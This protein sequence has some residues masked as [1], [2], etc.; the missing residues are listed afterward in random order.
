MKKRK[1][2]DSVSISAPFSVE[3]RTH[4][5]LE[6][7][8]TNSSTTDGEHF[9]L[10]E[11]I[12]EGSFG[13]VYKASHKDTHYTVA[14]KVIPYF[15]AQQDDT[16]LQEIQ[17]L[18]KC[19][20]PNV[21][22]YF[23]SCFKDN[24]LWILMDYC[25]VGSLSD[26]IEESDEPFT[27]KQIGYICHSTLKGLQFLHDLSIV[28]SDIKAANILL[29]ERGDIKLADFGVS[30]QLCCSLIGRDDIV[31]TPLYIAP[32]G[33]KDKTYG[34]KTDVWALGI[35]VIELA[36]GFP[37]Y[38]DMNP[39]RAMFMIPHKPPP[40]FAEPSSWSSECNAFLALCLVKDPKERASANDL[41]AHPFVSKA[42]G[43]EV[44]KA[45]IDKVTKLRQKKQK[46]GKTEKISIAT[47]LK[48]PTRHIYNG[49]GA[50]S[51]TVFKD[52]E[53]SANPPGTTKIEANVSNS[54]RN[55]L[56]VSSLRQATAEAS[57]QTEEIAQSPLPPA[58]E[59]QQI[60]VLIVIGAFLLTVLWRFL[61]GGC[62]P[63]PPPLECKCRFF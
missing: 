30:E 35:T 40:T 52:D 51:T 45:S 61:F 32:E 7:Q 4:V 25:A 50:F 53:P 6:Y 36:E 11:V 13:V 23:G 26:L 12:G 27:E 34:S 54:V 43:A 10:Q 15:A 56:K 58:L 39:I 8:W 19:K 41:I 46:K 57:I 38:I 20:H 5:D 47:A 63:P 42:K 16:L 60:L 44:L 2:R 33:I 3:H 1:T 14:V 31:G 48:P 55:S 9:Q 62:P 17:I 49:T 29:N 28:H 59:L 24:T 18:K 21:V 22:S 37:P